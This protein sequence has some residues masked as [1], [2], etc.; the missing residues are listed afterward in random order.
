VA[1]EIFIS[2][3]GLIDT[4]THLESFARQGG[5]VLADALTR[6]QAAGVEAMITIGTS[7]D[8]WPLYRALAQAHAATGLVRYSVGLHPC[9][10]EGDWAVA[11]AQVEGFWQGE[12]PRPVALGEIGLDRFH[13][14][15]DAAEAERIFAW[16]RAAF[17][18]GLALAKRLACPVV[19]HSRGPLRSVSQ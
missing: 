19:V 12:A 9:A 5:T 3:M 13:L 7:P 2:A 8:D 10:V 11:L 6:A 18:E 17:A 16:Q 4:H 1:F 15:K 14:P